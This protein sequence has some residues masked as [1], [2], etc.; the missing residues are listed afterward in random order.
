[1]H[2]LRS[3]VLK[4]LHEVPQHSL[5]ISDTPTSGH[6]VSTN[7]LMSWIRCDRWGRHT[8]CAGQGYF[9]ER[10]ENHWLKSMR[11]TTKQFQKEIQIGANWMKI[12]RQ[13]HYYTIISDSQAFFLKATVK[14]QFPYELS[15]LSVFW[16]TSKSNQKYRLDVV[17]EIFSRSGRNKNM[18]Q[19][20]IRLF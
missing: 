8:R 18:T 6:A 20:G 7:E 1:M 4:P 13:K 15:F 12:S 11:S 10:F 5:L 9:M 17:S 3:V 2:K 14:L 16:I 19:R